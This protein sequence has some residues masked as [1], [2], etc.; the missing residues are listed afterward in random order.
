MA[1]LDVVRGT[2]LVADSLYGL[3]WS[4][5]IRTGKTA[6]AINDTSMATIPISDGSYDLGINCIAIQNDICITRIV[7]MPHSTASQLILWMVQYQALPKLWHNSKAVDLVRTISLLTLL[8]TLGRRLMW[9]P[10]L[11]RSR[12][13][14]LGWTSKFEHSGRQKAGSEYRRVG[15]CTF[16]EEGR[17]REGKFVCDHEWRTF[18]LPQ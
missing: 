11:V 15:S 17:C 5:N 14:P 12:M 1:T 7:T 16:R 9:G 4:V 3:V 13:S 6:V 2:V 18:W 10:V 8:V